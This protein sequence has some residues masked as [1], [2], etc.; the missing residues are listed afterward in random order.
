LSKINSP[1]VIGKILLTDFIN[2]FINCLSVGWWVGF[3][4]GCAKL[5]VLQKRWLVCRLAAL[6][7]FAKRWHFVVRFS[8]RLLS[9]VSSA[10]LAGN[11]RV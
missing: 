3:G 4:C 7:I 5:N 2:R 6:L 10:T 11:G 9:F 8:V 1:I